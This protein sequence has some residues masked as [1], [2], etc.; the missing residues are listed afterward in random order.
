MEDGIPVVVGPVPEGAGPG[1]GATVGVGGSD[2]G[3]QTSTQLG[4]FVK[5]ASTQQTI[6]WRWVEEA[7]S[8]V[9]Q[10][11]LK[12]LAFRWNRTPTVVEIG[13]QKRTET[14]V[15]IVL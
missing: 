12:K 3:L 1:A 9:N 13:T 7:R 15:L 6:N 2:P 5:H 11:S 4:T 10:A 14:A 8:S